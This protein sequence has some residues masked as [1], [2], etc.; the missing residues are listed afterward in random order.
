MSQD[1]AT[2]QRIVALLSST[3]VTENKNGAALVINTA[4]N[5]QSVPKLL[6]ANVVSLLLPKLNSPDEDL[7][8]KACWAVNNLC[9][10]EEGRNACYGA[11]VL[12]YFGKVLQRPGTE[13][14]KK[15]CWALTNLA[16]NSD[17]Q[18][19]IV[20]GNVFTSLVNILV[21]GPNDEEKGFALQPLCNLVLEANNQLA[22]KNANGLPAVVK[23]LSS[24]VEKTQELAVTLVSFVTTNHDAIRNELVE[25]GVLPPLCVLLNGSKTGKLQEYAINSLVNLSLSETAERAILTQHAVRPVV[26]LLSSEDPRLAQQAAMLLSNLLTNKDI[27]ESVRY[28]GWVD[29]VLKLVRTGD[30]ATLQQVLRVIINICFDE[31]C[32]FLLQKADASAVINSVTGHSNDNN[33]YNLS[34]TAIKNLSVPVSGIIQNEVNQKLASGG[35]ERIAAPKAQQHHH[36]AEIDSNEVDKLLGSYGQKSQPSHQQHHQQH[37]QHHQPPQHQQQHKAPPKPAHDD[38]DDLLKDDYS[39]KPAAKA[40]PPKSTPQKTNQPN[41]DDLDLLMNDVKPTKPPAQKAPPSKGKNDLSDIDD[42]LSGI[43]TA[44]KKSNPPPRS[45][46]DDID[47]LLAGIDTHKP[48]QAAHKP[49]P[50]HSNDL[51]DIDDLLSGMGPSHHSKKPP[52]HQHQHQ[53]HHHQSNDDIDDLLEGIGGMSVGG[54]YGHHGHGSYG[55]NDDIDDL[56]SDLSQPPRQSH[57]KG[58]SSGLEAIDDLLA[59]LTG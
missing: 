31:P 9:V 26:G 53:H 54:G 46:H 59:D 42:L 11:G 30:S 43:D 34:S 16:R 45:T 44:P 20:K 49:P 41:Y 2:I 37:H 39:H 52:A 27:R 40:P 58:G 35:I 56:L 1:E 24:H 7:V 50:A 14:I 5:S 36:K 4:A 25:H 47:D 6:R 48:K 38:L 10:H 28:F 19:D 15:A 32:R 13:V 3:D 57:G 8:M 29:P 55:G 12:Q 17:A 21:Y 23:L 18:R 51:D 33:V 22:F